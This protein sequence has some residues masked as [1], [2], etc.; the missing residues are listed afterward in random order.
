MCF[1]FYLY[2]LMSLVPVIII[3]SHTGIVCSSLRTMIKLLS[4]NIFGFPST[5]TTE[6]NNHLLT[7]KMVCL[8]IKLCV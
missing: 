3:N 1:S 5:I 8:H 4:E 2:F 6:H 7:R